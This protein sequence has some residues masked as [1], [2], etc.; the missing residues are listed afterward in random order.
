MEEVLNIGRIINT[1]GIKGEVKVSSLTD[2]P[3]RYEKLKTVNMN[4]KG[5]K[6]VMT[7]TS[8]KYFKDSVILK[9]KEIN[10]MDA[11]EKL[12]GAMLFVE[13]KDAIK[14]PE[15]SFFIGDIIGCEVFDE[16]RGSLG[17]VQEV[18]QTG[19]NDVYIVNGSGKYKD[20][21]VPALKTVV[22]KVDIQNKR[23]D[24]I[25]PEGLLDD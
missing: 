11:A 23:I 2:D 10:D 16:Q 21:L 7:I 25:L 15:D 14:L 9:F 4:L 13:R 24:V 6:S 8:V 19:S 12:K 5:I 18:L 1:H 22:R 3:E 20:V 17:T